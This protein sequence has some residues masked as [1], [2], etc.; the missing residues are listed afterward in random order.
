M[1]IASSGRNPQ[2]EEQPSRSDHNE[3]ASIEDRSFDPNHEP[4]KE[5]FTKI[6]HSPSVAEIGLIPNMDGLSDGS[7]IG[8]GTLDRA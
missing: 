3:L 6:K 1:R 2:D 8:G 7:S 5:G 4:R